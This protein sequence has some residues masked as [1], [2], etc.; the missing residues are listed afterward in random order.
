MLQLEGIILLRVDAHNAVAVRAG[1]VGPAQRHVLGMIATSHPHKGGEQRESVKQGHHGKWCGLSDVPQTNRSVGASLGIE[2]ERSSHREEEIGVAA[3]GAERLDDSRVTF[4]RLRMSSDR[5][6][7]GIDLSLQTV[8][9]FDDAHLA[10][11]GK[12]EVDNR[13]LTV[14]HDDPLARVEVLRDENEKRTGCFAFIVVDELLQQLDSA[15][16]VD[17]VAVPSCNT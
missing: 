9:D 14:L 8:Q 4:E 11:N 12:E 13:A 5:Q 3:E 17:G 1:K 15:L 10:A 7:N 6:K 2:E 16:L